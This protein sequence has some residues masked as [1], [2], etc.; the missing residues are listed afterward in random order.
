[1]QKSKIGKISIFS[2]LN[3]KLE[4]LMNQVELTRLS[5]ES[6]RVELKIC[7]TRLELNWKCE[8][9]DFKLSWIQNVN[10]KLNLMI[11]LNVTYESFQDFEK[12]QAFDKHFKSSRKKQ[13]VLF[14]KT[15]IYKEY[16]IQRNQ[17]TEMKIYM[18]INVEINVISQHFIIKQNISLLN[19]DLLRF[20][21]IND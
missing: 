8:Q 9:L 15:F 4:F 14:V 17:K 6:S 1:M 5:V 3:V 12:R 10:S 20:I 21:W 7:S 18:N 19:V 13:E 2:S 16:V 11:S